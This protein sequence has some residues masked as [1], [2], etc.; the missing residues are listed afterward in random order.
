MTQ[1]SSDHIP[2]PGARV[3]PDGRAVRPSEPAAD[4]ARCR[5][6]GRTIDLADIT[7][8]FLNIIGEKDHI[9]PPDGDRGARLARRVRPTS[10]SCGCRPG[11]SALV[12][13]KSAQR[14]NLPAMAGWIGAA[15]ACRTVAASDAR[16]ASTEVTE[17]R[18]LGATRRCRRESVRRFF[19]RVPEGDRT[20]FRED[21]L[22]PGVVEQWVADPEQHRAG[23]DDRRRDRRARRRHPGRRLEPPRR[24][25]AAGRRPDV[26]P[27]GA[28]SVAG[29][30]GRRRGRRAGDDEA[31]RRGRRRA[32]G[33]GRRCSAS[34]GFEAEGLL[35]DHVR[36]RSG[37]VHDLLVLS[38]FVE[39]LWATMRDRRSTS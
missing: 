17:V 35:R 32:D 33:D 25:A 13:G 3:L 9:V 39:E 11:T 5:S 27:P 8:P 38:H 14:R 19:A 31:D 10:R 24:R 20:F 15:G 4:R 18:A 26:P 7:V 6:S 23:G 1:W 16:R 22:A 2:F 21:V 28:R 29:P 30:A 36:S 37:E 12:V 34:S